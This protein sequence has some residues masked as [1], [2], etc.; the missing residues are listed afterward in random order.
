MIVAIG[1]LL[2]EKVW[3]A[4]QNVQIQAIPIE[5][6]GPFARADGGNVPP[7]VQRLSCGAKDRLGESEAQREQV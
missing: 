5:D 6:A 1:I 3:D 7:M 4:P 2:L